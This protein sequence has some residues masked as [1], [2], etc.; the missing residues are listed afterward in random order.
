MI[1]SLRPEE[2]VGMWAW[3]IEHGFFSPLGNA[4]SLIFPEGSDC[5]PPALV[6]NHL[7]GSW[8]L[9]LQALGWGRYLA[10]RDGLAPILWQAAEGNP[11][12]HEGYRL[13]AQGA[14]TPTPV[15][16]QPFPGPELHPIPGRIEAEDY[17]LG[18]E[19]AA[20]HDTTG[21]NEGG[22]YRSDDVDIQI[23]TDLEGGYNV[24]WLEEGE[25]LEYAV[26]VASNGQY[27]IQVR[28]ASAMDRTVSETLP[29]GETVSW[30]VPLIRVLH[31][32]FD[33]VDVSG[34][35]PFVATGGWQNWTS[36]F[37]RRVSL[38]EGQQ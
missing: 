18:G 7:K 12:L 4:E 36:V 22:E 34:P 31:V 3:L 29:A 27:D 5:E 10:E 33:G 21:G 26:D 13:L 2:A 9:A 24:G 17:D 32:E 1:A 6:W 37:S 20:Y 14:P 15:T 30:T 25:W 8:N 11:L 38:S 35:V 16:P 28:V 19:G 23:T